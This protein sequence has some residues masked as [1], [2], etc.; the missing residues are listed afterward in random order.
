M[1][2]KATSCSEFRTS[3]ARQRVPRTRWLVVAGGQAER[4]TDG[5]LALPLLCSRVIGRR[6]A[7]ACQFLSLHSADRA[8]RNGSAFSHALLRLRQPTSGL[9]ALTSASAMKTPFECYSHPP[10]PAS[11][12]RRFVRLCVIPC[13]KL[14]SFPWMPD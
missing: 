7:K 8:T 1:E 11:S 4:G 6:R 12:N 14:T 2:L 10:T 5:W 3:L 9:Q 13:Y